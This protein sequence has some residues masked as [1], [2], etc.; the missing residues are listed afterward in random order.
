M[1][2][3]DNNM[4]LSGILVNGEIEITLTLRKK[5]GANQNSGY[6]CV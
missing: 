1:K 6:Y 2:I 4:L 3:P 5:I